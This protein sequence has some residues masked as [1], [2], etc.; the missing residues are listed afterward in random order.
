M[1]RAESQEVPL[2]VLRE[3]KNVL[4]VRNSERDRKRLQR[5]GNQP[6]STSKSSSK[7]EVSHDHQSHDPQSPTPPP[8]QAA[9]DIGL[10]SHDHHH[11]QDAP[12]F[13]ENPVTMT[14]SLPTEMAAAIKNMRLKNSEDVFS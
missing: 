4:T 5:H 10:R 14:T 9:H 13:H 1:A 3:L 11:D 7:E 12:L 2:H 6:G 8:S